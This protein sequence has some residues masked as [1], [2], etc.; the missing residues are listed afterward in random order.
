V[1]Y[2]QARSAPE[3]ATSAAA[4]DAAAGAC[5]AAPSTSAPEVRG[6]M[7]MDEDETSEKVKPVLS[8]RTH[9]LKVQN[10]FY[11]KIFH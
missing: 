8:F 10:T 2:G 9:F 6:A 7:A 3:G 1:A 4:D 11:I 5:A